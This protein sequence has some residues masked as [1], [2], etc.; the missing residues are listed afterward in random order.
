MDR[1]TLSVRLRPRHARPRCSP[2]V[3][4]APALAQPAIDPADD[5]F[6]WLEEVEGERALAWVETQNAATAADLRGTPLYDALYREA[7]AV[8]TSRRPH[9]VP[10]A[11]RRRRLQ[12]VDRRRAPARALAPRRTGGL[13]RRRAG[14]GRR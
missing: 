14:R 6:V 2:C 8:V 9:P 3:V 4:S 12:P 13:P 5:P 10:V 1:G 11:P 7:L